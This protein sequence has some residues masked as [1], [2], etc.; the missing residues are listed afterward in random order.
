VNPPAAVMPN[1]AY[2]CLP[3]VSYMVI[4]VCIYFKPTRAYWKLMR[5]CGGCPAHIVNV[6][7]VR[8]QPFS[9]RAVKHDKWKEKPKVKKWNMFASAY[10]IQQ[11]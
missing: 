1:T 5:L 2:T 9:N 10:F 4:K 8:E 11:C 7:R 3:P 6:V